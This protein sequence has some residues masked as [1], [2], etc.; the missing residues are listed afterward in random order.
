MMNSIEI[1]EQG[2]FSEKMPTKQGKYI[3][4]YFDRKWKKTLTKEETLLNTNLR[5]IAL[6]YKNAI[7]D[8]TGSN[9]LP[10][11]WC[12]LEDY[13]NDYQEVRT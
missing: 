3:T 6:D 9:F 5:Y 7:E 8:E 1:K 10:L 4:I 11:C 13:G 12:L 2:L